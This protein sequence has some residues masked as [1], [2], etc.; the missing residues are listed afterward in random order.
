M[1]VSWVEASDQRKLGEIEEAD[2]EDETADIVNA[3]FRPIR[4][5]PEL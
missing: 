1:P 2:W 3:V 5:A 4:L